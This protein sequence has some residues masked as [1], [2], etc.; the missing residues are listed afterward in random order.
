M[1]KN[2][3]HDKTKMDPKSLNLDL[4]AT[5]AP[6]SVESSTTGSEV[7]KNDTVVKDQSRSSSSPVIKIV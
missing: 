3:K 1:G 5:K 7:L 4:S 6:N 2:K